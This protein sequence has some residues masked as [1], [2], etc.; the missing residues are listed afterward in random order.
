M[1]RYLIE[2]YYTEDGTKG[3]LQEGGTRRRDTVAK[4]I[5]GLGGT[6]ESFYYTFGERD[7]LAIYTVPDE[8][9]AAALALA[10]NQSGK[11]R[12]TTHVLMTP[13]EVDE[14]AKKTIAYRAPGT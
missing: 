3:L 10:V 6:L 4:L 7:V 14:A 12:I 5:E 1:P 8:A 11:V 2:G 13:E 9:T